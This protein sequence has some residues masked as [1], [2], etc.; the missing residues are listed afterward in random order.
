V[1]KF[2]IFE[3]NGKKEEEEERQKKVK[4]LSSIPSALC[5]LLLNPTQLN[6]LLY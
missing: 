2:C 5:F 6:Q 3:K 4:L 1:D